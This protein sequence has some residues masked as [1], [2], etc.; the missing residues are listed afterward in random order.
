MRGGKR[1]GDICSRSKVPPGKRRNSGVDPRPLRR[2]VTV[3]TSGPT[4]E[5]A[6]SLPPSV[7][8]VQLCGEHGTRSGAHAGSVQWSR[9]LS[10]RTKAGFRSWPD[11]G[12]GSPSTEP[13]NAEEDEIGDVPHVVALVAS[14]T[15]VSTGARHSP[16]DKTD[17][18][19]QSNG[20]DAPG[21]GGASPAGFPEPPSIHPTRPSAHSGC[22]R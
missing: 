10:S 4:E 14:A 3:P 16:A 13:K 6:S 22:G 17:E 8:S 2:R 20:C 9:V 12:T 5:R 11:Q 7:G 1:V 21:S 15:D 19:K 18:S